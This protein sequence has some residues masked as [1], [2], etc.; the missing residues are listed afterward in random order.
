M[1]GWM[2]KADNCSG[3]IGSPVAKT[4]DQWPYVTS[5]IDN[6]K[7]TEGVQKLE[8]NCGHKGLRPTLQI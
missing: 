2:G 6:D 3:N 5:L 4:H 1:A 7:E 8:K